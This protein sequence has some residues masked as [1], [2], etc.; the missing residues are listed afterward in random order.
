MSTIRVKFNDGRVADVE[1]AVGWD[2]D[3][4]DDDCYKSE[5]NLFVFGDNG[6]VLASWPYSE[7]ASVETL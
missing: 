6:S 2:D 3:G 1:N 7:V 4:W 5:P